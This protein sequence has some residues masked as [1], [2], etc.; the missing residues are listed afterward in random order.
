ME[1]T[2][3]RLTAND[4]FKLASP[5]WTRISLMV[6]VCL[7]FGLFVLVQPFEAEDMGSVANE[8]EAIRFPP[9]VRI[10]PPP[11]TIA[12]P[13]TPRVS[14]VDIPDDITIA[15]TTIDEAPIGRPPPIFRDD[16]PTDRPTFIP[17]DTGPVILNQA[18]VQQVLERE[19]PRA[20]K[21]AGVEGQVELW[22]YVTEQGVVEHFEVKTSSG[23]AL[24]DEAAGRVVP[25]MR[26]A[27]AQSRDKATA[28]W[29]S[30]WV[31]FQV[32]QQR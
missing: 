1:D 29:V 9:E 25:A 19:Y 23:N 8:L 27:P 22:L 5:N 24:L 30:L 32:I 26:F 4:R 13:A 12:R 15:P 14:Q 20:L 10:P 6:A 2:G 7:H 11:E 17:Y 28:V 18:E 3:I 31:K 16:S 21:N